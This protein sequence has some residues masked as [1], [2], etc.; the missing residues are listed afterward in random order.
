M[1]A[2]NLFGNVNVSFQEFFLTVKDI[3]RRLPSS[4]PDSFSKWTDVEKQLNRE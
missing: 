2:E 3:L 1:H 4:G